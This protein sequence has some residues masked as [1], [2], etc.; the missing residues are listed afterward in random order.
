MMQRFNI[1]ATKKT[2]M[3]TWYVYPLVLGLI[4]IIWIWSF[5]AFHQASAYQSLTLFFA[6]EIKDESFA[7]DIMN[8]H[9]ERENLRVVRP[10][11]SLPSAIGYY[12]KLQIYLSDSDLLILDQ[13]TIDDFKGYQDRFFVPLTNEIKEK[14]HYSNFYTYEENDYGVLLKKKG[15]NCWLNQYMDFDEQMDYYIC[16][17]TSSV[18]VGSLIENNDTNDNALTYASYLLHHE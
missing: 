12:S 1:E 6:S 15:E 4:T 18:N 2:F 14:Y 8:E 13:K 10:F 3:H 5:M 17:S 16:F 9:Y 7:K 11:Y